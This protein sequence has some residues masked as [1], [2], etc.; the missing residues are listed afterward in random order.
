MI[1]DS[2][3]ETIESITRN[4]EDGIVLLGVSEPEEWIKGVTGLLHD[5]GIIPDKDPKKVW[6]EFLLLTTT[7]G[8]HDL[9]MTFKKDVKY[10]MGKMAM[11]RIRFGDCSWV[12]DYV[13][14]Y[15]D[16]HIEEGA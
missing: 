6:N 14:N 1:Q 11:W 13:V 5:E 16:Q 2:N 8:R 9:V 12:S 10:N 4:G 15:K 7:G 3:F